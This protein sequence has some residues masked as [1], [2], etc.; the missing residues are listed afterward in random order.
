[1]FKVLAGF[2]TALAATSAW[3]QTSVTVAP[4]EAWVKPVPIPT[5]TATDST[6][7]VRFLLQDIQTKFG[8]DGDETYGETAIRF[9]TPQGLQAGTVALP[10]NP[11][12][13]TLSVHKVHIVRGDQVIDVLAAGQTFTVLR[14]ET[15][16]EL[17]TLDGMLTAALQPEGLQVG[18]VLDVAFTLKRH[19]PALDGRS[20][21]LT[22]DLLP[23]PVAHLYLRE[24]W[25][26]SK[27][28][29]W[30]ETDGLAVPLVTKTA[31]GTELVVDM[32]N[33]ERAKAPKQAP[34]RFANVGL[35]QTTEFA[36]WA[37]VAAVM[38]P[39]YD[40]AS[41]LK[42]DSALNAEIAKIRSTS[43]DPT[44]QAAAALRLVQDNVRYVFLG[45]NDGGYVPA[46]AD[47]TWAR[48]FGDCKGKTALLVGLLRGLGIEAQPAL[49]N[50][51]G[52]D[53]L[54]AMLP[55][56]LIF[57]HV[58]VRSQI[59]GRVYWLDGT[60]TGDR[61]LASIDTPNFDWA[62]PVQAAGA[63]L[64]RL[65][66]DPP[67]FPL[68]ESI[69][70]LDASAG[71]DAPAPA[72]LET[73]LRGDTA[74]VTKTSFD[75]M[76]AADREQALR[77]YW[78]SQY[79]WIDIKSVDATFDEATGEERVTMDGSAKMAWPTGSDWTRQYE[80]DGSS[81][82]AASD[83]SRDAG[84]HQ[85]APIA[86]AFPQFTRVSET[87]VLPRDGAGFSV[88]APDVNETE[89]GMTFTRTAKIEHGVFSVQ[90]SILAV[91]KEF[92]Y[93]QAT[94]ATAKLK[95]LS[96]TQVLVKSP[97]WY[98]PTDA[99]LDAR[100]KASPTDADGYRDRSDA[101]ASKGDY[102]SALGDMDRAVA[103]KPNDASLLNARCFT[104]AEANRDLPAALD[105]CNAALKLSPRDPPTLDS[106]GFVYFRLG[107]F[108]HA[109]S[110]DDAALDVDQTQAP[111]LYIRGL[112]KRKQGDVKG[113]DADIAAAKVLDPAVGSTYARMGV[114][115]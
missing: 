60:R 35:L 96:Q 81:L 44:V 98:Q 63:K 109:I 47:V 49:V 68:I 46:S 112:A 95:A 28:M 51:H 79:S 85:D 27:A 114:A 14:R 100:I 71:L 62:L 32:A 73:V 34:P 6:A 70:H 8:A 58:L 64:Q 91:A 106:R 99:E 7:A 48:R 103:L 53:G 10:W 1:M 78:S 43:S 22:G 9:Q 21:T 93:N 3:A 115:P 107:Q 55:S 30:K 97:R 41:T 113:G 4:P 54:D 83:F 31:D 2:V 72:H 18:D 102:P 36:D 45:I 69:V 105:D 37:D 108:D 13:D 90:A 17:A 104:R 61:S 110:D 40:K 52:G 11:E 88:S 66:P 84:P 5:A 76:A 25:P 82:G 38:T 80:A 39:L 50:S 24:V 111:S 101:F 59:G 74:L 19:D 86:V 33:A 15:N 12:T 92:P 20:Q 94:I 89:A 23:I 56:T 77:K 65:M 26:V 67:K 57:D 75:Q 16:L 29:R 42:P 87:I